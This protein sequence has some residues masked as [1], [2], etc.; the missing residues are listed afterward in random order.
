MPCFSCVD[1]VW[2]LKEYKIMQTRLLLLCSVCCGPPVTCCRYRVPRDT[3][4]PSQ[5]PSEVYYLILF[6]RFGRVCVEPR[7]PRKGGD[8]MVKVLDEQSS[9]FARRFGST[10]CFEGDRNSG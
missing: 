2:K 7:K 6:F 4:G 5:E 3:S 9:P 1:S 8:E 10:A